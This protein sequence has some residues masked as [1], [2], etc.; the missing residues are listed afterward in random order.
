MLVNHT[1]SRK[2]L[3]FLALSL[4]FSLQGCIALALTAGSMVG[5]AGVNHTLS[6]IAYKTFNNSMDELRGATLITLAEMEMDV[7]LDEA[8]DAGWAFKA[9]AVDREIDIELERISSKTTRMRVVAHEGM[10]FFKD[11]ATATEIIIV[12]ADNLSS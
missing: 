7:T 10:I 4:L 12:T 3:P 11:S 8:N 6:G 9:D 1:I 2:L 5:S